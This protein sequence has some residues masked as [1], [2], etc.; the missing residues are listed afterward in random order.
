MVVMVVASD[1][2]HDGGYRTSHGG[3][4]AFA[5]CPSTQ[6]SSQVAK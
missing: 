1:E 3:F 5:G 4:E 2:L 6:V